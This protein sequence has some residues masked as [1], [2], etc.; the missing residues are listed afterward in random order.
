[1]VSASTLHQA[2]IS[3]AQRH[4]LTELQGAATILSATC[5]DSQGNGHEASQ[6]HS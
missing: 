1:M 2:C 6:V 3:I 4:I 5:E